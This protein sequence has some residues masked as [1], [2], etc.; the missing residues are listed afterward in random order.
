M[1][2]KLLNGLK[3]KYHECGRAILGCHRASH[4]PILDI[5]GQLH[6]DSFD[7]ILFYKKY[8]IIYNAIFNPHFPEYL[9]DAFHSKNARTSNFHIPRTNTESGKSAFTYWGP[10][11]WSSLQK[12]AKGTHPKKLKLNKHKCGNA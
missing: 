12:D 6:W 7:N 8:N 1:S 10:Y 3:T 9:K 2:D 4:K 5:L 11:I